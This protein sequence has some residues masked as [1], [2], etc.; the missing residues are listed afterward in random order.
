MFTHSQLQF[1]QKHKNTISRGVQ[2][3]V[4]VLQLH[5]CTCDETREHK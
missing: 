1:N 4:R 3:A 5:A 2:L